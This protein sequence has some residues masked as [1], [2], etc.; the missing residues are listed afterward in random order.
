MKSPRNHG[1]AP[2]NQTVTFSLPI[3]LARKLKEMAAVES[4][5]L[6]AQIRHLLAD[7]VEY[8]H[9]QRRRAEVATDQKE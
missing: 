2:D 8:W 5:S 6:S 9:R 3:P 1:R 7:E 4:R